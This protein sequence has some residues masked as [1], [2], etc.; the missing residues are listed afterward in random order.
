LLVQQTNKNNAD[1]VTQKND[2]IQSVKGSIAHVLHEASNF[3]TEQPIYGDIQGS[4]EEA[5]K[6]I[7]NPVKVS[8]SIIPDQ[9]NRN[10]AMM[11][12]IGT[13]PLTRSN[14][15]K[16]LNDNKK[17]EKIRKKLINPHFSTTHQ[18]KWSLNVL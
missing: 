1:K 14:V 7:T 17:L 18:A 3:I 16:F 8:R 9:S 10:L 12:H 4:V 13:H 5:K 2:L 15:Q 6:S 11:K